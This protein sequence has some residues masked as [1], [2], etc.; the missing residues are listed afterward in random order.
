MNH[1]Q[2]HGQYQVHVRKKFFSTTVQ[3]D[4]HNDG[5]NDGQTMVLS[6]VQYQGH[7]RGSFHCTCSNHRKGCMYQT[8]YLVLFTRWFMYHVRPHVRPKN[9]TCR[10]GR[11]RVRTWY[12][13]FTRW[14][15]PTDRPRYCPTGSTLGLSVGLSGVHVRGLAPPCEQHISVPVS[16]KP[17]ARPPDVGACAFRGASGA[18]LAIPTCKPHLTRFGSQGLPSP[19]RHKDG[20]RPMKKRK[21][22]ELKN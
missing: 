1:G 20:W 21:M 8:L 17:R 16:C 7:V 6:V 22:K 11:T 9:S 14:C 2:I 5:H 4:G 10:I 19:L 18:C 13:L 12:M 15:C 3:T